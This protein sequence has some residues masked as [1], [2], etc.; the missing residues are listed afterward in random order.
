MLWLLPGRVG[1]L[2]EAKSRQKQKNALTKQHH[3]QR[4]VSQ[5]WFT[6][7]YPGHSAVRVSVH[8]NIAATREAVP[9]GVQALTYEKLQELRGDTRAMFSSLCKSQVPPAQLGAVAERLLLQSNLR[10]DR[11][12]ATSFVDFQLV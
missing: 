5:L 7:A 6:S 9:V 1:I 2:I 3:G 11:L 8:P 4:L 12:V 10:S